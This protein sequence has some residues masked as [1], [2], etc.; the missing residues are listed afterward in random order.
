M[1]SP[2][3]HQAGANHDNRPP[4]NTK[5]I[6]VKGGSRTGKAS[7]QRG[8]R[9]QGVPAAKPDFLISKGP[10]RVD[11]HHHDHK[12]AH[13]KN[14]SLSA[15]HCFTN[16]STPISFSRLQGNQNGG[17]LGQTTLYRPLAWTQLS[18]FAFAIHEYGEFNKSGK[19]FLTRL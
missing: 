7:V 5:L 18:V 13:P 3:V 17:G 4:L 12:Q 15:V 11:T 9:N 16:P 14:H 2:D 8:F 1:V 6:C 10:R 19:F